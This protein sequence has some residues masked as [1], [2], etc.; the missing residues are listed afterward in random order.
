M[1]IPSKIASG[2]SNFENVLEMNTLREPIRTF[3]DT[4]IEL[5]HRTAPTEGKMPKS[6]IMYNKIVSHQRFPLG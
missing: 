2:D 5:I 6:T 3:R 1:K 4:Y